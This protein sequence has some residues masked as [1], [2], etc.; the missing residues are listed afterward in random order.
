MQVLPSLLCAQWC[1]AEMCAHS[2]PGPSTIDWSDVAAR[3][4]H[5]G[6]C[7]EQ[8][9]LQLKGAGDCSFCDTSHCSQFMGHNWYKYGR[10]IEPFDVRLGGCSTSDCRRTKCYHR[11]LWHSWTAVLR[12]LHHLCRPMTHGL[13][14][15]SRCRPSA[16]AVS[17]ACLHMCSTRTAEAA[18]CTPH[19]L[20]CLR[21]PE[22]LPVCCVHLDGHLSVQDLR[23]II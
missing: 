22:G 7:A 4:R 5:A 6:T 20:C 13:L 1:G 11:C 18:T 9:P 10:L 2:D 17:D 14:P 21:P 23:S 19:F 3:R 8:S 16:L 15:R 12:R